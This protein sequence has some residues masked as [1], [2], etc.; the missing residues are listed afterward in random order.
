VKTEIKQCMECNKLFFAP[1]SELKRGNGLF[2]SLS[3]STKFSAKCAKAMIKPNCICALCQKEFYKPQSKLAK[4]KSGLYF[5]CREHKDQAQRI[6][7]IKEIMPPHYGI[8]TGKDCYRRVA[9]SNFESKCADCGYNTLPIFQVHHINGDKGN[10]NPE[11]LVILCPNCHE[12]RHYLSKTGR[13]KDHK[14]LTKPNV[15]IV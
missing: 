5:C 12:T 7:G 15:S 14:E 3:C 10:N 6:G 13:Y 9:F 1:V 8:S 11:N 4:S 2:C